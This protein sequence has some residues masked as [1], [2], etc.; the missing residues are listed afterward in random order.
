M[1]RS[2][3][4][5]FETKLLQHLHRGGAVEPIDVSIGVKNVDPVVVMILQDFHGN[6]AFLIARP[7]PFAKVN[8]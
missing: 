6:D 4:N 8:V 3:W 1:G 2:A 5:P 7:G